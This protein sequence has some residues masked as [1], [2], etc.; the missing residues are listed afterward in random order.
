[1]EPIAPQGYR[2]YEPTTNNAKFIKIQSQIPINDYENSRNS[3]D[4][5]DV[6]ENVVR[7]MQNGHN[8][9]INP[10]C[11][12]RS[13]NSLG[14]MAIGYA[15]RMFGGKSHERDYFWQEFNRKA[16]YEASPLVQQA[17]MNQFGGRQQYPQERDYQQ[18][19]NPHAEDFADRIKR[20]AGENQQRQP[21][22]LQ[23]Q[24]ARMG[25]RRLP[26]MLSTATINMQ[27]PQERDEQAVADEIRQRREAMKNRLEE[28]A[29]KAPKP[30]TVIA[31]KPTIQKPKNN[32]NF[33]K[34]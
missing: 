13:M 34:I 14:G 20:I 19:G 18:I 1:M 33:Q 26:G 17:T 29:T 7:Y 9:D 22:P 24:N 8:I 12:D 25:E 16:G 28:A 31:S 27:R 3:E 30:Q 6:V 23:S 21:M 4:T 32:F 10:D 5:T 11:G 15:A 2:R